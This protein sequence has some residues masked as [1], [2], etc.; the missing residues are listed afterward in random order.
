MCVYYRKNVSLLLYTDDGIFIGPTQGEI[1]ECYDLL[2]SPYT[3]TDGV[4]WRSF[5]MTDDGDL[6]DYL[7]VKIEEL[8]NGTCIK[9]SQPHLIKG[10]LDDLGFSADKTKSKPTPAASTLK[11]NRDLHGEKMDTEWNYRSVIG[12]LNFL[13]K[14]TRPDLAY[15]VHQSN[16]HVLLRIHGNLMRRL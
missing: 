6:S 11:I 9:L 3:D 2:S 8:P 14:S 10:I 1:Q 4:I 5:K 13:E 15:S 7:G 12:K 16:A